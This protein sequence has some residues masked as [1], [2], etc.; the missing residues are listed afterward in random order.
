VLKIEAVVSGS[1]SYI[2]NNFTADT[3]FSELVKNA[4]QLGFT[5]P[6]P[7]EDLSGQDVK[8]K[9][10]IL[11]REAGFDIESKDITIDD[12]LPHPLLDCKDANSFFEMLPQY[13]EFF[14][15]K[16]MDAQSRGNALR[17]IATIEADKAKIGLREV[18]PISPFYALQGSD[19]IFV[20]TTKRYRERPMIIRGPGAGAEVTAAGVFADILAIFN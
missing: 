11:N 10:I 8:R 15:E 16:I 20:I 9:A 13:D 7:R 12:I 18:D 2:F 4:Q 17:F 14:K 3:P 6:D 1:L 19:N 5:E